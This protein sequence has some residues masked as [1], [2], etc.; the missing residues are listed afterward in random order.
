MK[1]VE[2]F[3]FALLFA[4]CARETSGERGAMSRP[5]YEQGWELGVDWGTLYYPQPGADDFESTIYEWLAKIDTGSTR[6]KQ[7]GAQ[8]LLGVISCNGAPAS[9]TS[10]S[11][12]LGSIQSVYGRARIP[13]VRRDLRMV[14]YFLEIYQA[15]T[16]LRGAEPGNGTSG[17]DRSGSDSKAIQPAAGARP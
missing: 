9:P 5:G 7:I 4:A 17:S 13:G 14:M 15:R 11:K 8:W 6:E 12:L 10:L 16:P 3:L 2:T 1:R